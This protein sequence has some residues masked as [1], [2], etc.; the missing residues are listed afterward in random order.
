MCN[1]FS[2]NVWRSPPELSWHRMKLG[3][4]AEGREEKDQLALSLFMRMFQT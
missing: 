4:V 2:G 1:G 3:P